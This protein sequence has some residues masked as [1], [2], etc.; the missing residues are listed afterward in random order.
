M[1][2]YQTDQCHLCN[3]RET[4]EHVLI[5]CINAVNLWKFISPFI[6]KIGEHKIQLSDSI[7]ILGTTD[8]QNDGLNKHERHLIN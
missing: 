5:H 2:V 7:K 8:Q 6:A 3:E 1:G 4:L